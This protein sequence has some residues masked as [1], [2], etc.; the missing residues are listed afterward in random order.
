MRRW[1]RLMA[2]FGVAA[3]LASACGFRKGPNFTIGFKRVALDLSYQDVA[4]AAPPTR[5]DVV[6][7]QPVPSQAAFLTQ[8]VIPPNLTAPPP[9]GL[10]KQVSACPPAPEDAH[11]D[12][13][14]T[15]F[16][17]Q[18]PAV[19]PYLTHNKGSIT[20]QSTLPVTFPFPARGF[21]NIQNITRTS[22]N[23]PV[24]GPTEVF[25][26]DVYVPGLDG[27]GTTTTYQVTYSPATLSGTVGQT[28]GG[29]HAPQG[30]LDLVRLVMKSS[31]GDIDF[32]PQP[33]VTIMSFKNGQGTSWNSGGIDQSD[34][35]S[36]VVQG[37][38][39]QRK[40]I[41]LCGNLY[42]TY[43]VI[44]NE[45]IVNLRTGLRSDTSATDPNVYHV[46]TNYGGLFIEQHIN[47][48]TSF[49]GTSGTP[50]I[51]TAVYDQTFDGIK[52][53]GTP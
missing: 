20:I 4:L 19:G 48:V 21:L 40:N 49:P 47:T 37:N 32:R 45:H 6:I 16:V 41:D 11:P 8:I 27:G 39:S 36:M 1:F 24:N 13:P 2:I 12:Q 29:S 14:A 33:P 10:P 22:V 3:L 25:T 35:T 9:Q 28:A 7:V 23:D 30:E 51:I 46:A 18:P 44:S 34:G 17:A 15:V 43:E 53:L 42:D 50:V 31:L 38:V 26:Y 52:P 5:Q